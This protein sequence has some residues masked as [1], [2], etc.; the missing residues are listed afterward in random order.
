MATSGTTAEQTASTA[1]QEPAAGGFVGRFGLDPWLLLAQVVNFLILL[2]IL[3]RFVFRPVLKLLR[4][5]SGTIAQG[6][7]DAEAAVVLKATAEEEKRRLLATASAEA[8]RKLRATEE[9]ANR[10]RAHVVRAAEEAAQA[11]HDRA[12]RDAA[13]MKTEAIRTAVG[14]VGDLVIDAL[15]KVLAAKLTGKER[16][17][18]REAALQSLRAKS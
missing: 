15:E 8:S 10:V 13:Q 11:M 7:Q 12:T 9:E 18:Y 1:M 3:R 4:A 5:R 2:I 14:E 17:E 6:L 16:A